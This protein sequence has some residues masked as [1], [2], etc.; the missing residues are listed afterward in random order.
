MSRIGKKPIALP[1]GVKYTKDQ[2]DRLEMPDQSHFATSPESRPTAKSAAPPVSICMAP[3]MS[4]DS[5]LG[6]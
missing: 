6:V 4:E 2:T 3:A 5:G 1:A